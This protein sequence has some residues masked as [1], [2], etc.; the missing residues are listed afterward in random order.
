MITVQEFLNR[1]IENEARVTH[2][3]SGGDGSKNGGCDCIGLILM[4]AKR[5]RT[6]LLRSLDLDQ[7][8]SQ[9]LMKSQ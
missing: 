8:Q 1:V 3:E 2:Y 7:N 6:I 4:E 9:I 5:S